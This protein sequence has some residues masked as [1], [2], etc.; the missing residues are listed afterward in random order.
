MIRPLSLAILVIFLGRVSLWSQES[1]SQVQ[2]EID[3]VEKEIDR[4]KDLHKQEKERYSQFENSKKEKLNALQEQRAQEEKRAAALRG[5]LNGFKGQKNSY[6]SQTA[7]LEKKQKDFALAIAQAAKNLADTLALD[8]PYRKESRIEELQ[9]VSRQLESG[10]ISIQEGLNRLF[11]VLEQSLQMGYG[12][13]IY[14][15]TYKSTAG[16]NLQGSYLK[17]GSAILVFATAD[18]KMAAYLTHSGNE[19]TW[20]D[21]ELPGN[22]R[23]G[24]FNA[25]QIAEGKA[26]P[27]MPVLPV[28]VSSQEEIKE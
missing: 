4:E 28:S 13:E 7:N 14:A 16:E 8:F 11:G 21:S 2:R 9:A 24:I 25:I 23:Q 22:V 17:V 19:Y 26:A 12:T 15:G 27:A 10:G 5:T 20:H 18:G 3:R 1:L 6:K